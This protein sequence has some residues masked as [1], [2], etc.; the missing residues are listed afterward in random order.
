MW[1]HHIIYLIHKLGSTSDPNNYRTIM[2][3]H[4]FSKLY[5]IVLYRELSSALEQGNLRARGRA[6]FK[7]AHQTINHIF[8]L[9]DVIKEARR[10]SSKVYCCFVDFRKVFDLVSRE[11]LLQ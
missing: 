9:R 11:D 7:P 5:A 2:V 1:S 10:H 6:R 8:T 3:G 4:T